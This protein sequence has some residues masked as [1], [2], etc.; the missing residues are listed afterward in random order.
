VIGGC[1]G[2]EILRVASVAV[3]RKGSGEVVGMASTTRHCRMGTGQRKRSLVMV[4]RR[5]Y[6]RRGVMAQLALLRNAR[7]HVIRRCCVVEVLRMAGITIG[8]CVRELP[9]NMAKIAGYGRVSAGEGESALAMI[10][11][12]GDP[13][14]CRVAGLALLRETSLNVIRIRGPVVVLRVAAVAV[15]RRALK[16]TVDMARRARERRMSARQREARKFEVV[17]LRVKPCIRAVAGFAGWRKVESL[18]VGLNCV[19]KIRGMARDAG[20]G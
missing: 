1:R 20:S 19:L 7:L 11:T 12:G 4:K 14:G 17:K 15:R 10:E 18:V 8:R 13:S 6:P 3:R 5:R 9:I 16:L 2:I